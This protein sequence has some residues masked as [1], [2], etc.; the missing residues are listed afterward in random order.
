MDR[1]EVIGGGSVGK[2]PFQKIMQ[3][4]RIDEI[5]LILETPE[6]ARWSEEIAW[7]MS[8]QQ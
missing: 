3:D 5:P 2:I 6:P 1:H 7:L 8:L 4:K